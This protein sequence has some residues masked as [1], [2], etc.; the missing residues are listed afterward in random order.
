MAHAGN[1]ALCGGIL[2]SCRH[3]GRLGG[4]SWCTLR[5]L[6][7]FRRSNP[8]RTLKGPG[9]T[10]MMCWFLLL[11]VYIYRQGFR[12]AYPA[13]LFLG[14]RS[15]VR[16]I[17][18]LWKRARFGQYCRNRII[19]GV[20]CCVPWAAARKRSIS[21]SIDTSILRLLSRPLQTFSSIDNTAPNSAVG[22]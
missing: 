7:K 8:V 9:V 13:S 10:H 17:S 1:G 14:E 16:C 6:E 20:A 2:H 18:S 3:I 12:R 15:I 11:F 5:H 19:L 22:V 21:A 4:I